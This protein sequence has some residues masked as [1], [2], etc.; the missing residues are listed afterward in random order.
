MGNFTLDLFAAQTTRWVLE[1]I[2][3]IFPKKILLLSTQRT[4]IF[5]CSSLIPSTL[6]AV[7]TTFPQLTPSTLLSLELVPP[8][9]SRLLNTSF[10]RISCF[11]YIY[12]AF[13]FI[14]L[15]SFIENLIINVMSSE[16]R[17]HSWKNA[18]SP[19]AVVR[20]CPAQRWWQSCG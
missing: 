1:N 17:F 2:C 13:V 16:L 5:S 4:Q 11:D 3:L 19:S 10:P 18:L 6:M 7:S 12:F 20:K 14:L 8:V 9:P 15:Q